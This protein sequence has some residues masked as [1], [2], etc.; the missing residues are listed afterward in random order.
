MKNKITK[1]VL[2]WLEKTDSNNEETIK[3]F[4]DLVVEK[5]TDSLLEEVKKQLKNEFEI[6]NL[7]HD[8]I[9]SPDYYLELKLKEAKQI[10]SNKEG[11]DIQDDPEEF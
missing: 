6:G 1:E 2:E 3:D 4:V 10:F 9:I 7:K 11:I 5:T 8:F